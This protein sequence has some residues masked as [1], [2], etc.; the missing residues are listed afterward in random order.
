MKFYGVCPASCGE[1]VQG[2]LD[3]EEYNY[4]LSKS[5]AVILPYGAG[6][7]YR[8]S[9]IMF[10]CVARKTP[11][12]ASRIDALEAFKGEINISF[13]SNK[14]ELITAINNLSVIPLFNYDTNIFNPKKYWEKV[15]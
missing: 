4:M 8:C 7:K 5:K 9:G 14:D 15:L 1:F 11:I 2:V 3:N 10:E 12:I 6:F 13:F